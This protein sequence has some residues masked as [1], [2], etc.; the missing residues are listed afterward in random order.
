[1][2]EAPAALTSRGTAAYALACAVPVTREIR[3][4]A[5]SFGA[6]VV[7]YL[8]RQALLVEASPSTIASA[9]ED[10]MFAGACAYLPSDKV[11]AGVT[12]GEVTVTP[13]AECDRAALADFISAEGG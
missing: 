12:E 1:M 10:P 3:E 5:A 2:P 8:P 13:V 7:G 4:L 9:L 6:R 11:R